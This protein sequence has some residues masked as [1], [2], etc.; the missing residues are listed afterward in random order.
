[1]AS[2]WIAVV[3]TA[4]GAGIGGAVTVA[5]LSIK[6]KQDADARKDAAAEEQKHRMEDRAWQIKVQNVD[7]RRKLYAKLLRT[8]SDLID[9]L[10]FTKAA[11]GMWDEGQRRR[12]QESVDRAKEL[13][14]QYRELAAET[15][16]VAVDPAVIDLVER[17]HN[18]VKD[19]LTIVSAVGP[20]PD[21]HGAVHTTLWMEL[22][23][24]L[25]EACRRDLGYDV[26]ASADNT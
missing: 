23:P 5:S 4:I 9:A 17:I 6:G 11:R 20:D 22:L 25:R 15:N 19:M 13:H 3:G 24:E 12:S 21:Q 7:E 10:G 1:V 16:V 26:P 8:A 18:L 14:A 2:E